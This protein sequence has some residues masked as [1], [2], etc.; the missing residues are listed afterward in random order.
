MA[1]EVTDTPSHRQEKI[2]NAARVIGRSKQMQ[3]VFAAICFGKSPIKAIKRV[4]QKS[5]LS[6]KQ[7]LNTAVS[8]QHEG[9]I[10]SSPKIDGRKAYEKVGFYAKN[11]K[12]ILSLARSTAKLN[13]FPTAYTPRIG[14]PI[15]ISVVVR[16]LA[17]KVRAERI[18]IDDID[19]FSKVRRIA[20]D[21]SFGPL[22]E[23]KFK[24]GLKRLLNEKGSFT[25]WGGET[26]DLFSPRVWVR[27]KRVAGSFGLKGKATKGKLTP[28]KM[29]KNGDQ[30]QR[31]FRSPADVFVVQYWGE[32]DASIYELMKSLASYKS[33][34][35]GRPIYYAIIDGQ[36]SRRLIQAYPKHFKKN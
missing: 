15:K 4:Q 7:V 5:G 12:K 32:I 1:V 22:S 34:V 28:K 33:L 21:G 6:Y 8:L 11:C 19:S 13:K 29:G 14:A 27:G 18:T 17:R 16:P 30:I 2:A 20:R 35:E 25:D 26:D 3:D 36:D 9:L 10:K 31:L 24:N 23:R